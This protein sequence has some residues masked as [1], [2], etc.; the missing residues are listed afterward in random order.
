MS[1]RTQ[2]R[3][4]GA[5]ALLGMTL[6]GG[7]AGHAQVCEPR[8]AALTLVGDPGNPARSPSLAL[9]ADGRPIISYYDSADSQIEVVKCGNASCTADNLVS[10]VDQAGDL[11]GPSSIAVGPEGLPGISYYESGTGALRF[12]KCTAADCRGIN[13]VSILDSVGDVGRDPALAIPVDGRPVMSY[14]DATSGALKV[15][16]CFTSGCTLNQRTITV[17]D[18]PAAPGQWT[19]SSIA[20]PPD[21]RPVISYY[22][23]VAQTLRMVR[24]GNA[25]CSAGNTITT[26]DESSDAVGSDSAIAIGADGLPVISYYDRIGETLRV[27][28][29][30]DA[31]CSPGGNTITTVDDH[32]LWGS[33]TS[34]AIGADGRPVVSYS[35]PNPLTPRGTL[36]VLRC[37]NAACT[38]NNIIASIDSFSRFG[39]SHSVAVASDGLPVVAYDGD[40]GAGHAWAAKCT[41][42]TC[43]CLPPGD[44]N[45]DGFSDLVWRHSRS[46]Q[47]VVWLMNGAGLSGGGFTNPSTFADTDWKVVGTSDFNLDGKADLLWRHAV[48]GQ[49]VVWYMNGLNLVSGTFTS[50]AA[51]SD[52]RWQM[53]GTADFNQDARPD[54]LWRHTG[55]GENVVWFMNGATLTSGTFTSPTALADPDWEIGGV[56][57]F[58]RDTRPDILWHHRVSG[59]LVLWYMQGPDLLSATFL[60]PPALADVAWRVVAVGDYN[61]DERPDIVWRHGISGQNVVWFM[62]GATLLGGTLTSPP[63]LADTDWKLV[64]PR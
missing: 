10:A 64:G 32:I 27:A 62:N 45:R 61:L 40:G 7:P 22:H 53:A 14:G 23:R 49:N 52:I 42:A 43:R 21:G 44:V 16:R 3:L 29:C 50:P 55:S 36:K 54:I 60:D 58:N 46:G 1:A 25:D 34:I 47:N 17:V 30:G 56:G 63:A 11:G 19:D 41:N 51:L 57:D 13:F 37:G 35:S 28:K 48:S 38:A 6:L 2:K 59:Q 9:P 5:V 33:R 18:T 8:P 12:I 20:V 26:V 24:C 39:K 15:L 31:A 4:G